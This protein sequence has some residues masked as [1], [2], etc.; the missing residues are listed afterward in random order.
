MVKTLH[1]VSRSGVRSTGAVFYFQRACPK[2]RTVRAKRTK[3]YT[4]ISWKFGVELWQL[5]ELQKENKCSKIK[6]SHTTKA[7]NKF[8]QTVNE[9]I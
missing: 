1:L 3:T 8:L 6:S 2:V 7:V 4:G 5:C 9:L